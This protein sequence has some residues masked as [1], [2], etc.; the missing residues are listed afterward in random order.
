VWVAR[1]R[2]PLLLAAVAVI[3]WVALRSLRSDQ[4]GVDDARV[5]GGWRAESGSL[6]LALDEKGLYRIAT[7]GTA[8]ALVECGRWQAEEGL[9]RMRAEWQAEKPGTLDAILLRERGLRIARYESP[10]TELTLL[11][12]VVTEAKTRT[13]KPPGIRFQRGVAPAPPGNY[14]CRSR[15]RDPL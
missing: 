8:A 4:G 2:L 6:T 11:S 15:E 14:P 10:A 3:A 5:R 13:G 9:I 12:A 1:I 7:T